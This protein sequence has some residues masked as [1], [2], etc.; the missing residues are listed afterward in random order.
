MLERMRSKKETAMYVHAFH[1]VQQILAET[2]ITYLLLG[3]I[4][5]DTEFDY[6]IKLYPLLGYS[7]Y[8]WHRHYA[9]AKVNDAVYLDKLA[10]TLFEKRY[11]L[12]RSKTLGLSRNYLINIPTWPEFAI[13]ENFIR[14]SI[15]IMHPDDHPNALVAAFYNNNFSTVQLLLKEG[16]DI[17][18]AYNFIETPLAAAAFGG[19]EPL[20]RL[21][22]DERASRA[23]G[24][25]FR[26]A[27][28]A[29]AAHGHESL[30]RMLLQ[31]YDDDI[32]TVGGK[33]G[34]ALTAAAYGGFCLTVELLLNEGADVN[35]VGGLYSTAL[36]AAVCYPR[37][38]MVRLLLEKGANVNAGGRTGNILADAAH[39]GSYSLVQLLLDEGANI[40]I[41]GGYDG[42]VLAAA[43]SCGNELLVRKLLNQGANINAICGGYG[44]ALIAAAQGGHE[45]VV[46]VLLNKGADIS[47]VGY[48]Y[49]TALTAA[50]FGGSQS[51][52]ELLLTKGANVNTVGG[53]N[54]GTALMAAVMCHR[55]P[56]V[57]QLLNAG[58][59]VNIIFG[60]HGTALAI[61]A[62][63]GSLSLV[64]LLLQHGANIMCGEEGTALQAAVSVNTSHN[65]SR[66]ELVRF[67]LASGADV[68]V[69]G[70]RY[71]SA[72]AGSVVQQ[73]K[74]NHTA[75]AGGG[76]SA[77]RGSHHIDSF[78]R[79]SSPPQLLS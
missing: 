19:H 58:A 18:T 38:M 77:A 68:N 55:E 4:E 62:Y 3:D 22:L 47:P 16:A 61:A 25:H 28:S 35:V 51:I 13:V 29:A 74:P 78:W 10:I 56:L 32:N 52:V 30:V 45:S 76:R 40:H 53:R 60:I 5:V 12:F 66:L 36:G 1:K 46:R 8:Y 63:R 69:A 44:T 64:R 6:L 54:A 67:L 42:T 34:T 57:L 48:L 59:D 11:S 79:C 23:V 73:R 37:E 14:N 43:A 24:G 72:F 39:S 7:A 41:M 49:R 15:D 2:C 9:Y 70:G 75:A 50:A 71:G 21:L 27:L 65:G 17:N 33:C 31:Q 26:S 20:V